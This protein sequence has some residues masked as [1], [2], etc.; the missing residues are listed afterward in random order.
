M[1]KK[2]FLLYKAIGQIHSNLLKADSF[3]EAAMT[4]LKTVLSSEI[5]DYAVIW[6]TDKGQVQ[7]L[8]PIFWVCPLDISSFSCKAGEGMPG[9]VY[10]SQFCEIVNINDE[11]KYD[12]DE[13]RDFSSIG[14]SSIICLPLGSIQ[15]KYGVIQFMRIKEH[16]E[17][18]DEEV[19]SLELISDL[20]RSELD[21]EAVYFDKTE[22]REILL[23]VRNL[24][25]QFI[26]GDSKIHI[27]KGINLD[28][29]EGEFLCILGESGS[30]K[31]TILNIIG[32]LLESDDGTVTF[33][34]KTLADLSSKEMT[35]Y[36]R[37]NIGFIFQSYNLMLT[38]QQ[39]RI[40]ILLGNW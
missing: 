21:S 30:G 2:D 16:G 39:N 15:S 37:D 11:T 22:N 18:S 26:N 17:F 35:C 34:A 6:Q 20:L 33:D 28:V 7:T 13:F 14:I 40:L 32:G 12:T 8:H 3:E 9:R 25:K 36:R 27:L 4:S 10:E 24:H 31:S 19:D 29:Y 1:N 5:A 23:S 38:L